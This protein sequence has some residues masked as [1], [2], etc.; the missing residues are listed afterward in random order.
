VFSEG[1]DDYFDIGDM[2]AE[3]VADLLPDVLD[4]MFA[5]SDN[6]AEWEQENED[7]DETPHEFSTEGKFTVEK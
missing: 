4:E 2:S 5:I 7:E 6:I 1:V 3:D